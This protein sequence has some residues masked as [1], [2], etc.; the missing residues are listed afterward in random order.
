MEKRINEIENELRY[1]CKKRLSEV[2]G[3]YNLKIRSLNQEL[4]MLKEELEKNEFK[5][6]TNIRVA[7]KYHKFLECLY[8]DIEGYRIELKEG[9]IFET[10]ECGCELCDTVKEVQER[11]KYIVKL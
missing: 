3:E 2:T 6:E 7:K 5:N 11:I 8:K 9:Y 4:R 1:Y 10:S